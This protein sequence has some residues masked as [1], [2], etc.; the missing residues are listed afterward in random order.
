MT[1]LVAAVLGMGIVHG[2]GRRGRD[3][4]TPMSRPLPEP[5]LGDL[6]ERF[7][8]GKLRR[9]PRC[10]RMGLL[11]ACRA[12]ASAGDPETRSMGLVIGSAHCAVATSLDYMDSLLDEGPRLSSPTAFSHSVCNVATGLVGM[13]LDIRGPGHAVSQFGL[14]FAGALTAAATILRAGRADRVLAGVVEEVDPRFVALCPDIFGRKI[15]LAEGDVPPPGGDVP[16]AE[17]AVVLCLARPDDAPSAPLLEVR[18]NPQNEDIEGPLLRSGAD[19]P[20]PQGRRMEAAYGRT[21][22]AQALDACI[23]LDGPWDVPV[24]S[25]LHV[26]D[27][28]ASALVL[29]RRS[30]P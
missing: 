25:C 15:P 18:W 17:G 13:L 16:P 6:A 24:V 29:A 8:G 19:A 30:A 12:L 28:S 23:A 27:S 20:G 4:A 21:P 10:V 26:A 2:K 14:S 11:A 22:M 3:L 5:D 9:V 7:P 1:P